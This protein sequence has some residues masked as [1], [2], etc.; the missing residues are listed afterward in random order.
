MNPVSCCR[1]NASTVT[2]GGAIGMYKWQAGS[3]QHTRHHT[4]DMSVTFGG[5]FS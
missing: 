4:T 2:F 5:S 1:G 3:V